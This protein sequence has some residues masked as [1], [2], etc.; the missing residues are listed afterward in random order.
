MRA[1]TRPRPSY[2]TSF[3]TRDPRAAS[4]SDVALTLCAALTAVALVS[5]VWLLLGLLALPAFILAVRDPRPQAVAPLALA[6]LATVAALCL[7]VLAAGESFG[8]TLGWAAPG[9]ALAAVCL[10][11]GGLLGLGLGRLLTLRG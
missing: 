8:D 10:A 7:P 6:P 4:G 3:S 2:S 11:A 9:A 1:E 5:G